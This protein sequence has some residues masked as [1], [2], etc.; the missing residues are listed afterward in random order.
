MVQFQVADVGQADA[1]AG[2]IAADDEIGQRRAAV[3][4][5]APTAG[6]IAAA[7]AVVKRQRAAVVLFTAA[8][9]PI[10]GDRR[11]PQAV[12]TLI[13]AKLAEAPFSFG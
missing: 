6:G 1:D 3:V 12:L 5:Q 11:P 9:G 8:I 13:D 7:N 10:A 4:E 2:R